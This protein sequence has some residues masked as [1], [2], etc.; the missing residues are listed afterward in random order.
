MLKHADLKGIPQFSDKPSGDVNG[1]HM[2]HW[3]NLGFT[4]EKKHEAMRQLEKNTTKMQK[5]Y[6]INQPR[7]FGWQV[8]RYL[9]ESG[10]DVTGELG[11]VLLET[12]APGILRRNSKVGSQGKMVT[13][14]TNLWAFHGMYS[15]R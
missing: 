4:R 10:V 3:E 8:M 5:K 6:F 1:F 14:P 2:I 13:Q 7:I 11:D 12:A 9:V 15:I